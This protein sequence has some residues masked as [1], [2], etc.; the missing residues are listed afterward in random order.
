MLSVPYEGM[1]PILANIRDAAQN[2]IVV[3]MASALDPERKSR[4]KVPAAGSIT[5]ALAGG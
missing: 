2:K 1:M 5:C 4:A 3:N